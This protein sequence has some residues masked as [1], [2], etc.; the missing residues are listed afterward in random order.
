[1][2]DNRKVELANLFVEVLENEE[3]KTAAAKTHSPIE[4]CELLKANGVNV[5][6]E[7]VA[8][9]SAEGEEHMTELFDTETGELTETGLDMVAGGG[10]VKA[11]VRYASSLVGL[12]GLAFVLGAA[13]AAVAPGAV[14]AGCVIAAAWV[15]DG[16][17]R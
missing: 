4:L 3:F 14:V 16:Y 5:T 7:E 15:I 9:M 2:T 6:V 12:G 13:G 8:E 10:K 1:M 11:A 17:I